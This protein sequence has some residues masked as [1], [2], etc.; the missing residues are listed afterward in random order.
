MEY[1]I[2]IDGSRHV[3]LEEVSPR[4]DGGLDEAQAEERLRPLSR[5]LRELQELMYAAETNGVLVILQ[6]M[7]AAGKDVTIRN[8]FAAATPEAIRVEHFSSMTEEEEAHD[9]LWRAHAP[10]PRRGQ[11]V[12]FDRSYYEQVVMPE[13]EGEAS[14]EA[15]RERAEDITAFERILRRGGTVVVKFFLHVSKEEQERRLR[16]RMDSMETAW[17]I[18][19]RDWTARRSWDAYMTAYETTMNATAT[20]D[21]PWYVVPADHQWFHDLAVAEALVERLRPHREAWTQ[22]RDRHGEEKVAEAREH[23]PE[24]FTTSS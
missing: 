4:A 24:A 13:V 5:E 6:G 7:D 11:L 17:K 20:P 14:A 12:I 19:A 22:A 18:S 9:F 21:A 10:M 16:E 1:A 15:T 3:R 23:A 8:V 2:T